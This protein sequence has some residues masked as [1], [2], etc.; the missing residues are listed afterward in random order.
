MQ[1]YWDIAIVYGEIIAKVSYG[2][3]AWESRQ[4]KKHKPKTTEKIR[5]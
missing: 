5:G 4:Q 1:V 3:K 2:P